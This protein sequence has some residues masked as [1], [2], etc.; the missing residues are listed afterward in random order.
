MASHE[1]VSVSKRTTSTAA[2]SKLACAS[3]R[4]V[5]VLEQ[6]SLPNGFFDVGGEDGSGGCSTHIEHSS[7]RMYILRRSMHVISISCTEES[8]VDS[9]NIECD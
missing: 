7:L 1:H 9:P 2:S 8:H 6:S 3:M 4:M 5:R